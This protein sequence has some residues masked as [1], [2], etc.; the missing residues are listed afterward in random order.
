MLISWKDSTSLDLSVPQATDYYESF[1]LNSIWTCRCYDKTKQD[2]L[3]MEASRLAQRFYFKL[4]NST[5]DNKSSKLQGEPKTWLK[6]NVNILKI[7]PVRSL[8]LQGCEDGQPAFIAIPHF[9]IFHCFKF[10]YKHKQKAHRVMKV[11]M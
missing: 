2:C 8:F 11:M 4:M 5:W 1:V 6:K 3:L 7:P 9:I 10:C